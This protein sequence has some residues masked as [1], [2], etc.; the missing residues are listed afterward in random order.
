MHTLKCSRAAQMLTVLCLCLCLQSA[1]FCLASNLSPPRTHHSAHSTQ[2]RGNGAHSH[3]PKETK[4]HI[5][6][7]EKLAGE[8][9]QQAAAQ[10]QAAQATRTQT[11]AQTQTQA[12]TQAQTQGAGVGQGV[13]GV[14]QVWQPFPTIRNLYERLSYSW[15]QVGICITIIHNYTQLY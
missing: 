10:T 11:H 13:E 1:A 5:E 4:E 6:H 15:V 8:G 7:I 12:Q 14:G 2:L 9:V 3:E